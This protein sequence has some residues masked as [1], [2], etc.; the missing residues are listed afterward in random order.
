MPDATHAA[1][2]A[3]VQDAGTGRHAVNI[4]G[5]SLY[6]E[7]SRFGEDICWEVSR[8]GALLQ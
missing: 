8:S 2:M 5:T 4:N 3:R 6:L 1:V 7:L